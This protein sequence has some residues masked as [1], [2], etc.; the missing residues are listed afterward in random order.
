MAPKNP[1]SSSRHFVGSSSTRYKPY[2]DWQI[3]TLRLY[4]YHITRL[5]LS[6]SWVRWNLSRR[7]CHNRFA[8][9]ELKNIPW[10]FFFKF[11]NMYTNK[12]ERVLCIS[13]YGDSVVALGYYTFLTRKLPKCVW[14]YLQYHNSVLL[15]QYYY[16]NQVHWYKI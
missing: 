12:Y 13:G 10:L 16:F 14:M 4:I 9:R 15:Q 8:H 2:K 7:T 6:D 11:I 3:F 5:N 1:T